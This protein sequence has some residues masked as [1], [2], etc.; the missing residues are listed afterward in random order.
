MSRYVVHVDSFSTDICDLTQEQQADATTV[1]RIIA[2]DGCFSIF[3][4]TDNQTIAT[5]VENLQKRGY[6]ERDGDGG[7]YP[8][9]KV[10]ATE[11]GLELL[12]GVAS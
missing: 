10:K 11:K 12:K 6:L 5:T 7:Q 1:L 3:D 4:V 2:R 8:W 9:C